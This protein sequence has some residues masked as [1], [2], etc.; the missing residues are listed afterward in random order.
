METP[1]TIREYWFGNALEDATVAARE[2]ARLWWSK[3]PDVDN[4]IRRRFESLV[5]KAGL[6]ELGI[7][8]ARPAR[9]NTAYRSISPKYLSRFV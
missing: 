2:R 1:D 5:I 4:E 6:G 3:N 7:E 9:T 8:S